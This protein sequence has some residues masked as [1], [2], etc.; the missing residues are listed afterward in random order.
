MQDR[1]AESPLVSVIVPVRNGE[2]WITG[3]LDALTSQSLPAEAF[4]LIVVDNGSTDSTRR[5]VEPYPVTVI[6]ERVRRSPYAARNAGLARARGAVVAFTD[7]DCRP[8]P[9][10]LARGTAPLLGGQGDLVAGRVVFDFSPSPTIGELADAL[11]H[12]DVPTQVEKNRSAMTS[13]LFVTRG[14]V[15]ALGPFDGGV[16]SGGDGRWTRRASDAGFRLLYVSEATVR[17]RSRRLGPLLAKAYRVGTG[18]PAVW[19]ERG[20][21]SAQ[22]GRGILRQFLPPAG[23]RVREQILRR[24]DDQMASR[25]GALWAVT[26]LL[27]AV[28][29]VGALVGWIRSAGPPRRE[30]SEGRRDGRSI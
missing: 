26:W 16:R 28:R 21:S 29:G 27:E 9:D 30:R 14:V 20:A 13:N 8:D 24:G 1:G 4:E 10:W 7:A 2:R 12:L 15:E 5:L 23:V 3:C 18:L 25:V 6:E 17:K 22:L 11:W 19:V